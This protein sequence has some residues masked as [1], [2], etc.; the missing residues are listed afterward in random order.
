MSIL[1][2]NYGQR[3]GK[4]EMVMIAAEIAMDAGKSVIFATTDQ[5]SMDARLLE[6]FPGA[7]IEIVGDWGLKVHRR[8][9]P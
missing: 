5:S 1:L 6:R 3:S 9:K 2:E 4:T 8:L 7:L